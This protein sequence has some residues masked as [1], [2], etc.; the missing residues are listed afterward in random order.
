MTVTREAY[1]AAL[2]SGMRFD[3]AGAGC[4]ADN[5][6]FSVALALLLDVAA[7]AVPNFY[8]AYPDVR[9][10]MKARNWLA[11]EHGL[12]L[13][14]FVIP[15]PPGFAFEVVLS[16]LNFINPGVPFIANGVSRIKDAKP[17]AWHA[18][19]C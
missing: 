16:D 11:R 17:S 12:S 1:L 13:I 6:C 15:W 5:G 9:L 7:E 14:H 4:H 3:P 18:V 8:Y 2:P 19:V 10:E